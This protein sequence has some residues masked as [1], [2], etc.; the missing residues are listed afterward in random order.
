MKFKKLL[1]YYFEYFFLLIITSILRLLPLRVNL[2]LA[3]WLGVVFFILNKKHRLR[4]FNN[5]KQAFPLKSD[6]ELINILKMV[7]INLCK[8]YVEFLYLPYINK[9]YLKNKVKIIGKD[10]LNKALKLNKGIIGVTSHMGNW[11]LLGAIVTKSDYKLDVVYHSMRN[12]YSDRFI[13][14]I[15]KQAG[16]GLINMN[17]AL[18]ASLKSLKVNHILGLIADQDA[19]RDGVF[20]DFFNRPASTFKGPAFFALKTNAPMILFTLVR[21]KNDRHTLYISP[22]LKLKRTGDFEKDIYYNTKLWS[23]ELQ[24]WISKYPQ[25]WFW[26]H[27]RWQTSKKY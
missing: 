5:L 11:E 8:V 21:E 10:N 19:G 14:K 12:P 13:N 27:R 1:K 9:K 22:P 6:K 23:D 15:R 2:L 18:R 25:Q 3:R 7:Y 20:I 24:K 4:A 16:I 17:K 26:V